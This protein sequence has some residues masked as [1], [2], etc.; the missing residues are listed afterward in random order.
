MSMF[1]PLDKNDE[2]IHVDHGLVE[3]VAASVVPAKARVRAGRCMVARDGYY[4]QGKNTKD[5]AENLGAVKTKHQWILSSTYN[6]SLL[7]YATLY[8]RR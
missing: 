1:W 3:F 2:A 7:I 5:E 4:R 6:C 8:R